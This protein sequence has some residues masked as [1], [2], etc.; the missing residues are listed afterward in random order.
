MPNF[1]AA[2]DIIKNA[3]IEDIGTG[4]ITTT[5]CIDQK[6]VSKANLISKD[7]G[8]LCGLPVFARVLTILDNKITISAIKN[9]GDRIVPG[10]IIASVEG[11]SAAILTGE[12]V[13][14]NFLQRLSGI[15]TRTS[16]AVALVKGTKTK[17]VDTRKTTPGLRTLEKYAV[18]T[19]GG[20]NHRFNLADGVL[21][22]DNHI[23]AAGSIT[24]AVNRARSIAPHALRIEVECESIAQIDEA[25]QAGVDTI[26]LDN[27][28]LEDMTEA[29][30]HINDQAFIEASGNMGSKN[31]SLIAALGIDY[32]SIG[33][34]TNSVT[35]LDISLRFVE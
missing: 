29:V 19:G 5:A 26:M 21:I 23:K 17:I 6:S 33:A 25:L 4:D 13:A 28:T 34:L 30:A 16:Q 18:R 9:D 10:D 3:L 14:L 2:D 32:I 11:P 1:L 12:R 22:K 20:R 8:I 27:M 31:L 15:A 24:N 35:A 7:N